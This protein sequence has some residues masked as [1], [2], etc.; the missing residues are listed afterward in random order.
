MQSRHHPQRNVLLQCIGVGAAVVP[1][2]TEGRVRSGSLYLL[3]SD[4]FVHELSSNEMEDRLQPN[5]LGAKDIL[6]NELRDLTELCKSR[7]ETDNITEVLLRAD[8]SEYKAISPTLKSLWARLR[9][10][11]ETDRRPE[12]LETAQISHTKDVIG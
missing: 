12:L 2:F 4:G 8:E 10:S 7:G 6:T 3:C 5:I 11:E 1:V 9:K